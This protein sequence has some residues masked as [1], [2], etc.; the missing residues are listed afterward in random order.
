MPWEAGWTRLGLNFRDPLTCAPGGSALPLEELRSLYEHLQ[1]SILEMIETLDE[2][3]ASA[4][5]EVFRAAWFSEV[6]IWPRPMKES[7]S[8]S[9]QP[10]WHARK[11][12]VAVA[13]TSGQPDTGF[14]TSDEL[15]GAHS[16][17]GPLCPVGL[18]GVATLCAQR[19]DWGWQSGRGGVAAWH[20]QTGPPA[21]RLRRLVAPLLSG[22][23]G[24]RAQALW[25][26]RAP[27][28]YLLAKFPS[29]SISNPVSQ[30][31]AL[32]SD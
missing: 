15:L 20:R 23:A 16:R 12:R 28:K 25:K 27:W 21:A 18:Q 5:C 22:G 19:A 32:L 6:S 13:S 9:W 10:P 3:R 7:S 1:L 11:R 14:R 8:A 17:R 4:D 2:V 31:F 30:P 24:R 26:I 29:P